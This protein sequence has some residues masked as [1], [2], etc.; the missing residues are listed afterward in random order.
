MTLSGLAIWARRA[1]VALV[2][3]GW[4]LA[5]AGP[6]LKSEAAGGGPPVLGLAGQYGGGMLA[7]AVQ[8]SYA[9]VGR[10]PRLEVYNVSNPAN[11]TRV[12]VS[13][14]LPRVVES[15]A[16]SGNYAYIT[17][18]DNGVR[19]LDV[20]SPAAPVVVGAL[21]ADDNAAGVAVAGGRL[22]V[23]TG[24]TYGTLDIY[25]LDNPAVPQL[26]S[27]TN[28]SGAYG[29][30][31]VGS[32][33]YVAA[34]TGGLY[35][36]DATNP[37]A[38][39]PRG[40]VNTPGIAFRVTVLGSYAYVADYFGGLR[41]ISVSNPDAPAEAGSAAT[42][43][44]L[45]VAVQGSSAYVGLN[46]GGLL[47]VNVSSPVS[48]TVGT[49][50]DTQGQT[51][52]VTLSGSRLYLANAE[53]GLTIYDVTTPATPSLLG[54]TA[55][56]EAAADL[57][58]ANTLSGPAAVLANTSAGVNLIGVTNPHAPILLGA[59]DLSS[60]AYGV[61]VSQTRAYVANWSSGLRVVN[62]SNPL[63]P[64]VA[65][66]ND[67]AGA[68]L[69]G[70]TLDGPFAFVTDYSQKRL[71]VDSLANPVTPVT[72]G[73][74]TLPN[75]PRGVAVSNYYAYVADEY[76]GLQITD[77]SEPD[78]P[79]LV[80]SFPINAAYNVALRDYYA[81]VSAG[82]SGLKII[83]VSNPISP[84]QT[85]Q[86]NTPGETL[87]VAFYDDYAFLA[88]GYNGLVV[89]DISNLA[90]PVLVGHYP[91]AS[92]A[93]AVAVNW[94]YVYVADGWGGLYVFE[95]LTVKTYLPQVLR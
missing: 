75:Y 51:R 24:Y 77:V 53:G 33:V 60:A 42:G 80:G 21:S 78:H 90:Q 12:G 59:L 36:Y 95:E 18:G 44:A 9:Y 74:V 64:T 10:G 8:G 17:V 5:G 54:Q 72:T 84:T 49:A 41:V 92:E 81:F 45:A 26:L 23:V 39:S 31:V 66:T 67:L 46:D 56:A 82:L 34:G 91:T 88:D 73:T 15:I 7:V 25:A 22:Y 43:D 70:V 76:S 37:A 52:A 69:F 1:L 2:V 20:S 14:V 19:V 28:I 87:D 93:N 58:L 79:V 83:H 47:T 65:G 55:L 6:A 4:V 35:I 11:P 48:P 62:I 89:L 71:R 57:A 50:L 85:G 3:C 30:T 16:L 86:Y 27:H 40:S 61:V 63:N 94:P 32:L 68:N 29:L 38:P 13:A